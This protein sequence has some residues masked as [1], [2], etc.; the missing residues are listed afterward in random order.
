MNPDDKTDIPVDA[1]FDLHVGPAERRSR[2]ASSNRGGAD[3]S[4]CILPRRAR[5]DVADSVRAYLKGAS[6]A[7]VGKLFGDHAEDRNSGGA[8]TMTKKQ[9]R[10]G[11]ASLGT[12]LTDND[13]STIFECFD[14]RNDGSVS[15]YDLVSFCM[16]AALENDCIPAGDAVADTFVKR[17]IPAK[18]F[19]RT[20]HKADGQQ[21]GFVDHRLF[22]KAVMKLVGQSNVTEDQL[23]DMERFLDPEKDGN[24][25]INYAA[26]IVTIG[27]DVSR[28]ESKLRNM[29]R[30]L[31]VRGV[32]YK[33]AI[34]SSLRSPDEPMAE[35]DELVDILK[36]SLGFPMLAYE[37]QLVI[38]KFQRRGRVSIDFFL[39]QLETSGDG[40]QGGAGGGAGADSRARAGAKDAED[41]GKTLFKK[42]CKVRASPEKRELFRGA[43]LKKDE[44]LVGHISK[45]DLQRVLDQNMDLTDAES[46]LLMENL[47]FTDG[48]HRTDIQYSFLLLMLHEP[49]PNSPVLA[50]ISLMNKMMRGSDSV[51]LRRLLALLF[52]SFAAA[53]SH[54]SGMVPFSMAQKVLKEECDSVDSNTLAGLLE[55]FQDSS[56]DCILYPELISFLGSCSLWNVMY[57]LNQIDLIRQRQGYNFQD[58]LV[59]YCKKGKKVDFVKLADQFLGLGILIPDTAISTIFLNYGDS[60]H[61]IL[62]A[63]KFVAAL[64]AAG[65]EEAEN[66]KKT[67]L[68][69]S[70]FAVTGADSDDL[71]QSIL[72]EYDER[73]MKALQKAFDLF[74]LNSGNEIVATELERILCCVGFEPS[75]NDIQMLTNQI[76]RRG[77]G[78]LEYNNFMAVCVP[79][80]R[81]QYHRFEHVSLKYLETLFESLDTDQTGTLDPNEFK[82]VIGSVAQHSLTDL[83]PEE[84]DSMAKFLDANGDGFVSWGEFRQIFSYLNNKTAFKKLPDVVRVGLL[85]VRS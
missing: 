39:E 42:L 62:D 12:Q 63:E 74:D 30:I 13:E 6:G 10:K 29:L 47:G 32:N 49:I 82:Q 60:T 56:S 43:T 51:N 41:F 1:V 75:V 22:E 61:K 54:H 84:C 35:C 3:D 5:D 66:S 34:T 57:R 40:K 8:P 17:K 11:F 70:P 33:E 16:D 36:S 15:V 14:F 44:D 19:A 64:A 23:G 21:T 68:E 72:K 37:V 2:P 24:I 31:R 46:L 73:V 38:K 83:T 65:N 52:R 9:M 76:D 53:D 79:Y 28:A 20:L 27:G 80:M 58:F 67:R 85:K 25:D 4:V 77:T 55:G 45:R 18:E 26:A 50:G 78:L 81:E 69:I 7:C 59:K 71:V 48:T